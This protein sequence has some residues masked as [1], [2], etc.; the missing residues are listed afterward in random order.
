MIGYFVRSLG[1]HFRSGRTLFLLSVL[2]VALGVASVL[3]IQLINLNALG[4]FEASAEAISGDA[5][6][7]IL[8]STAAMSEAVYLDVLGVAGVEAA[9]PLVRLDV[10]LRGVEDYHLEL[11]G[12]DLFAPMRLPWEVAPQAA[13]DPL[14]T[15]GWVAVSPGL[16]GRFGWSLG[17]RFEVSSGSTVVELVVGALVD[18]REISPAASSRMV[19]IDIAQAQHLF[20]MRGV[21]QQ[22]DLRLRD[23]AVAD[24][25][26][27]RL[28]VRVDP[29]AHVRTPE[30]RRLQTAE[31]LGAFRLNLTALSLISLFV[32]AFLV[33]SATRSSLA[34][35]HAE[36][37]L[38]RSIGATG[39]QTFGLILAEVG[40]LGLLGV[41]LGLPLGYWVARRNVEIVSA[42]LSNIYLLREIES[43]VVPFRWFALAA[44]I[45]IGGALVGAVGP[46]TD[47]SRRDPR[48]L[49]AAYSL[50]DSAIRW[51][52][53]LFVAGCATMLLGY[54][55]HRLV[56]ADWRPA[57]F[58]VAL[59]LVFGIPMLAPWTIERVTAAMHSSRFGLL[60]GVKA[61]GLELQSSAFAVAAL[62]VAVTM[63][64][65]V[66]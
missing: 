20:G 7:S 43:L 51:S 25:V 37:G 27:E 44:A 10:A 57:G 15:P 31:L 6:L 62:A 29:A 41:L 28:A 39:G 48:V 30:Q 8:P 24:E 5:D 14:T 63:L 47:F 42:T 54:L 34:R 21:V 58:L 49:L 56:P 53:P 36:F 55:T 4:A 35:R 12:V 66:T 1:A 38:L 17:D 59:A 3:S 60:H 64:V 32:G 11:L 22:I 52:R 2:G 16:A 19:V 46:A 26:R 9:W 50:R 18:F 61:L 33:Y 45:G 23:G 40:L 65:G 13:G